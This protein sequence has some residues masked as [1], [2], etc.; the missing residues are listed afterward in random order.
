MLN[1]KNIRLCKQMIAVFKCEE[2]C[3]LSGLLGIE[4]NSDIFKTNGNYIGTAIRKSLALLR[5]VQ[6]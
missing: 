3:V 1:V 4:L 5:I 6:E 2:E